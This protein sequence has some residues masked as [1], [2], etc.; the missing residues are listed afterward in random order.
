MEDM[1]LE[2]TN[3]ESMDLESMDLDRTEP[4]PE[5]E[6]FQ[7][8]IQRGKVIAGVDEVGR[9]PLIGAV[10]AGAVVLDPSNPIEGLTD[11]KKLSEKKRISLAEEIK[12]KALV[13]SLGRS[14]PEEIDRIN[15]LQ[16]SLL[17]MKRAVEG[18]TVQVDGAFVDGNRAPDLSCPAETVIKGDLIIPAISAASILAKVA[19]DQEMIEL[20]RLYPGY[21]L[22]GHKGYPTKAHREALQRLGITPLHRKSFGP[23]KA[24]L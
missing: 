15:I 23:V 17:A 14:E 4:I 20:D 5:L 3:L 2:G 24:L 22:A 1:E 9:G 8:L 11:S 13:W 21:G 6:H 16:A 7:Q 10:V 19:R 18:L 12:E